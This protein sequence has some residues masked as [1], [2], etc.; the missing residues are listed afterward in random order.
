MS[1]KLR[2]MSDARVGSDARQKF[3]DHSD[4]ERTSL[5]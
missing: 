3:I 5:R 4:R 2:T 1:R